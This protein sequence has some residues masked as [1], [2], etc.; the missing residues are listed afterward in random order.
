MIHLYIL[1][2]THKMTYNTKIFKTSNSFKYQ[3]LHKHLQLQLPHSS[4]TAIYVHS[5]SQKLSDTPAKL[6]TGLSHVIPAPITPM[7]DTPVFSITTSPD[8]P[9]TSSLSSRCIGAS[10]RATE[11]SFGHRCQ[12]SNRNRARLLSIIRPDISI[13]ATLQPPWTPL[14]K[15]F[16]SL[17][18]ALS[19]LNPTMFDKLAT[20][21]APADHVPLNLFTDEAN[22]FQSHP[23]LNAPA[24]PMLKVPASPLIATLLGTHSDLP[25]SG[26]LQP[27]LM[28]DA[29][30]QAMPKVPAYAVY[31]TWSTSPPLWTPDFIAPGPSNPHDP[32]PSATVA[33][34]ISTSF[35][36]LIFFFI[37]F[38]RI[39]PRSPSPPVIFV[40]Y[41][42]SV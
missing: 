41:V 11:Y 38:L 20:L 9:A 33:D 6:N 7:L 28:L 34:H 31:I 35:L 3:T 8:M 37:D 42:C 24:Q 17:D 26:F 4:T 21:E 14:T 5:V 18:T 39:S 19:Y 16:D 10:Q 32:G 29:P 36:H 23:T 1:F 2:A 15:L 12:V 13:S 27:N 25:D 30:A 40:L 22:C